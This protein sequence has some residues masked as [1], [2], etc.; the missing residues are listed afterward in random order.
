[1]HSISPFF[2]LIVI[3][4]IIDVVT[5]VISVRRQGRELNPLARPM[6]K[7][8]GVL[9][10]AI[11]MKLIFFGAIFGLAWIYPKTYFLVGVA[12]VQGAIVAFS[13]F[14]LL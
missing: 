6:F 2:F 13:L 10:G 7:L 3:L 8:F 4:G 1:M 14:G 12:F 9:P 11:I 5:T